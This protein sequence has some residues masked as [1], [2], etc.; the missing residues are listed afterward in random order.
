MKKQRRHRRKGQEEIVG[1]VLIV[2]IVAVVLLVL[3]GMGIRSGTSVDASVEVEHFLSSSMSYTTSCELGFGNSLGDLSEVLR[4]CA[5]GQPCFDGKDSCGVANGTIS[6]LIEAGWTIGE[7]G[8]FT[9]YT[10]ESTYVSSNGDEDEPLITI[11][12]GACEEN[13]RGATYT[14]PA[15]PGR[16]LTS[17]TICS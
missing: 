13:S 7:E 5:D 3:L 9:G 15:F 2:V 16:V 12:Q 17:F 1:F 14:T 6:S 10:W 8:R 11:E 4:A